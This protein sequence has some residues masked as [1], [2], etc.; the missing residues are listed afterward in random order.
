MVSH[1]SC[2][3]RSVWCVVEI[4]DAL[5]FVQEEEKKDYFI[6]RTGGVVTGDTQLKNS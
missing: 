1:F 2:Q 6:I 5:F 4:Q 3:P